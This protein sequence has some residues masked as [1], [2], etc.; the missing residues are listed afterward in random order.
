MAYWRRQICRLPILWDKD[1]RFFRIGLGEDFPSPPVPGM[2][3]NQARVLQPAQQSLVL[4]VV[5]LARCC[6]RL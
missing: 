6:L 3:K 2:G 5:S 1:F 4:Q